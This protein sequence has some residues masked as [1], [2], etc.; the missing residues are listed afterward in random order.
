MIYHFAWAARADDSPLNVKIITNDKLIAELLIMATGFETVHLTYILQRTEKV[1]GTD[2]IV[3][4]LRRQ[5][6]AF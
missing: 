1:S 2:K 4:V 6:S 5:S 3:R